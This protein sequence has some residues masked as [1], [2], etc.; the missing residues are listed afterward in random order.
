[1]TA[2][3]VLAKGIYPEFNFRNSSSGADSEVGS[4]VGGRVP[5]FLDSSSPAVI[6]L[7]HNT[8]SKPTQGISSVSR[9]HLFDIAASGL[10]TG[11]NVGTNSNTEPNTSLYRTE[12]SKTSYLV[13][14]TNTHSR[15]IS[16]KRSH[17]LVGISPQENIAE[18]GV[19]DIQTLLTSESNRRPS[20]RQ[21]VTSC[22]NTANGS[23]NNVT[24]VQRCDTAYTNKTNQTASS[25]VDDDLE[26]ESNA[27]SN[28]AKENLN[29]I[30]NIP[31]KKSLSKKGKQCI[32]CTCVYNVVL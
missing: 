19:Q 31:R 3:S 18:F 26:N 11:L 24:D 22:H 17:S 20:S 14:A 7:T 4:N 27:E 28:N 2:Q 21:S 29:H 30:A 6:R 5:M 25:D 10:E 9:S 32:T 1:M 13:D 23:T 16:G 8:S 12:N 15:P